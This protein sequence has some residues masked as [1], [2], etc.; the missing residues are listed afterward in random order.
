MHA[1]PPLAALLSTFA[2]LGAATPAAG[3]SDPTAV[4][5]AAKK[6]RYLRFFPK[7]QC[8]RL[9]YRRRPDIANRAIARFRL[10]RWDGRHW[11]NNARRAGFPVDSLP[12]RGDIAVWARGQAGAR[13]KGHVA[14]V[15]RVYAN[16]SIRVSEVNWK[17]SRRA[18]RRT[19]PAAV[20][21]RLRFIH[22]R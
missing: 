21:R 1:R 4:G 22:R 15:T 6:L 19:V 12:R 11:A 8:T 2:L 14:Y 18:G 10:L 20:V 17:E 5:A 13:A 9:A 7:G 16:G 3:A